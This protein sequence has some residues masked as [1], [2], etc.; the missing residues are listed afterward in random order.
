MRTT[1]ACEG[2][3]STTIHVFE[4][5]VVGASALLQ[6]GER[7]DELQLRASIHLRRRQRT[8]EALAARPHHREGQQQELCSEGDDGRAR[9]VVQQLVV[10]FATTLMKLV[11]GD[12]AARIAE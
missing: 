5:E 2:A 7:S 8:G 11:E 10:Q 6:F 4:G 1:V 9:E 12:E 3:A